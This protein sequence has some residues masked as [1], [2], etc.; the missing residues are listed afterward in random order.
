[1][2][3]A[4]LEAA[5]QERGV[6]PDEGSGAGG[7]VVKDDLVEALAAPESPVQR[8]RRKQHRPPAVSVARDMA[9]IAVLPAPTAEEA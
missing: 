8:V 3:V 2:R 1:M 7:A 4:D 9:L 5:A 6:M